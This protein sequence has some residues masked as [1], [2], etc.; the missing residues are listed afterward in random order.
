MKTLRA[1]SI[2]LSFAILAAVPALAGVTIQSPSNDDQ[3]SSP[4]KL[5]AWATSCSSKSVVTMGYSFDSSSDAAIFDGQSIDKSIDAP[6]G[7]HTLHVKAWSKGSTCVA[8]VKIDIVSGDSIIPSDASSTSH[9]DSASGWRASHDDGGP[10]SSDGSMKVVSS[11]SVSGSSREFYTEFSH[12]GDE[13]Y[14]LSFSDD[15]DATHFF[16][17]V[18]VYLTSSKDHIGNLEFDINQTMRDGKTAMFGI[19]CSGYSEHWA[20]TEN[21]GSDSH[22]KPTHVTRNGAYCNPRDWSAD[23]WHHLQA[24]VSRDDSGYIDYRSFWLD[25]TEFKIDKTVFGKYDLGWGR[26]I[27]TQFQVD[28]LGSSGHSTVYLSDLQISRW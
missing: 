1:L 27:N 22:P 11:P 28:G 12:N 9:L 2:V 14:S 25:G 8:D 10:G 17:D 7:H 26:A 16:Y 3:V 5:S 18:W 19:I 13:R 4:L 20:Y 23:K 24:Y 15:A 6:S 21:A